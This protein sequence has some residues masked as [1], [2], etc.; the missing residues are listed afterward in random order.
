MPDAPPPPELDAWITAM[1]KL[2]RLA[3]EKPV[4]ARA[5]MLAFVKLIAAIR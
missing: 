3:I 2:Q 5:A 1:N 4:I